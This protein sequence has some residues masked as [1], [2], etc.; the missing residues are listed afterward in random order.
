MVTEEGFDCEGRAIDP[1]V[2]EQQIDFRETFMAPPWLSA[3]CV[4]EF[5]LDLKSKSTD[6]KNLK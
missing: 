6:A 4:K 5:L 2:R 1:E 3:T